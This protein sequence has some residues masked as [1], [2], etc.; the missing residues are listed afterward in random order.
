MSNVLI[1]F[2]LYPVKSQETDRFNQ[3]KV[4]KVLT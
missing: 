1:L 4:Y 3:K 2:I